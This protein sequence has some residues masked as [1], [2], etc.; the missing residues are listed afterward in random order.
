M[1]NRLAA[2]VAAELD[3]N[4]SIVWVG[5]PRLKL[6]RPVA[7]GRIAFF[8]ALAVAATVLAVLTEGLLQTVFGVLAGVS[9][10][11]AIGGLLLPALWRLGVVQRNYRY[12]LTTR[13]AIICFCRPYVRRVEL[14]V[15]TPA[16][17]SR[18][19]CVE[20][21]DGSGDLRFEGDDGQ[22]ASLRE[23]FLM[24]DRVREVE[25]LVRQTLLLK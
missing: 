10:F 12:V 3:A 9:W 22:Y 15:Y 11:L 7:R 6:D 2:K 17:L 8:L 13:R 23:G 1:P 14:R 25:S 18:M 24:I 5:Q 20:R 16:D 21:D 19:A 4:E